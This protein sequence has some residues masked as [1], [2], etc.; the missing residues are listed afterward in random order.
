MFY[1]IFGPTVT[2]FPDKIFVC[3]TYMFY[4]CSL[5]QI[6][7]SLNKKVTRYSLFMNY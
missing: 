7:Y 5:K 3:I 1:T 2:A 4:F 6:N